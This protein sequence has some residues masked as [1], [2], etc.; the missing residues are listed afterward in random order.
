MKQVCLMWFVEEMQL[1]VH[2]ISV[3]VC[4]AMGRT[5]LIKEHCHN[6]KKMPICFPEHDIEFLM[7]YYI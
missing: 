2:E 1:K 6:F 5:Q 3:C 7:L 4:L